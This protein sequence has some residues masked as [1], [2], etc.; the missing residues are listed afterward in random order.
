MN[1]QRTTADLGILSALTIFLSLIGQSVM[2][3]PN[4]ITYQGRLTDSAGMNV[5][6]SSYNVTFA[7]YA[8]STGGV[9]L[10][11]ES[12]L[13]LTRDGLFSHRLGS[14]SSFPQLLFQD[15]DRLYLE[16]SIE[17]ET[18]LPRTRLTSVPYA[19]TASN[20]NVKNASDSTVI[21]TFAESRRLSIYGGVAQSSLT[22]Q[23]GIIGDQAAVLPDSSIN[24]MEIYD[25]PGIAVEK[26]VALIPLSTTSM[27]DLV[28]VDITIPNDGY[29]V[30]HGKCYVLLSGTTGPNS[31]HVQID[32]NEGGSSLFPYYTVAGLGGYVNTAT[33][34]FPIYVTRTYFK[35]AGTYTF[36]MEGRAVDN[37]PAV[38]KT[39][40]HILTAVYYPTGY[41]AVK[42]I[43]AEPGD[44][45]HASPITITDDPGNN[46]TGS[47]Y[48]MDLRYYEL[49]AKS[50]H[51]VSAGTDEK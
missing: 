17:G 40:D 29:I 20:L 28:T 38:A 42:S 22:L 9:P 37:S 48:E 11:Q 3:A 6:D 12:A 45:P 24:S 16:I 46:R 44:H 1:I 19:K 51:K 47:Y 18:T 14:I 26:N 27:T 5:P 31:A 8:D 50:D 49:R 30:L 4:L 32:E 23:G 36:R 43:T 33:N 10:W 41:G 34:Y 7:V 35:S 39:W 25:E 15:Q 21:K 2:T 13:V